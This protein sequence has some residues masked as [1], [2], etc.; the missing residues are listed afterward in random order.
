M[1]VVFLVSMLPQI[2]KTA[3]PETFYTN[4]C[5]KHHCTNSDAGSE[6]SCRR[7]GIHLNC[8][9]ILTENMLKL[10]PFFWHSVIKTHLSRVK[11]LCLTTPI[12]CKPQPLGLTA[13]WPP[14]SGV[15]TSQAIVKHK[16]SATHLLNNQCDH[17]LSS[18][19]FRAY[20]PVSVN[21]CLLH[22][23]SNNPTSNPNPLSALCLDCC[24]CYL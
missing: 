19:R 9:C 23:A 20:Y 15:C 1:G 17:L 5:L 6:T 22:R 12:S 4:H 16:G 8:P 3:S 24:C 21:L 11:H 7:R 14:G 13:L 10:Y 2:C 18:Y